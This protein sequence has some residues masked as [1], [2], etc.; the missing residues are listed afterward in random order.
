MKLWL[1]ILWLL[2]APLS[3]ASAHSFEPTVITLREEQPGRFRVERILPPSVPS[4]ESM[5][6]QFPSHCQL[7]A[8][9]TEAADVL[10]HILDCGALGLRGQ[11]LAVTGPAIAE[12]LVTIHFLDGDSL[13]A[14][15][16]QA[17]LQIPNQRQSPQ[18]STRHTIQRFLQLGFRHILSGADHL[19][20]LLGLLLLA[21]SVRGLLLTVTAFT[22]GH[23]LTLA[24]ST[25]DLVHPPSALIEAL[26][27]LSVVFLAREILRP[28][29]WLARYRP[30][31]LAVCFGLLHG[32]GFASALR[33]VDLPQSQLPL[34]LLSF[35]CGVEL[36]QLLFVLALLLPVR[37]LRRLQLAPLLGYALGSV[38]MSWTIERCLLL[39]RSA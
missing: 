37:I 35:N 9:P 30:A 27:A 29:I 28:P 12:A 8:E 23:S 18:L 5:I 13:S 36:G 7:R 2:L 34:S 22:V 39:F 33:E 17:P 32:L 24:L 21:D 19:L 11:Q 6:P 20:L 31:L 16:H 25:L 1:G 26:I 15:L 10:V 4:S 14:L 38:A 3:V